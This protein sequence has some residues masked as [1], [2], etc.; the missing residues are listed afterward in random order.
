MI[1]PA[2]IPDADTRAILN[3]AEQEQAARFR[4]DKDARHWKACRTGLKAILAD[5]LGTGAGE[6]RLEFEEYGKPFLAAPHA[7][8][9][10]NL[11]HCHDLALVVLNLDGPVGIDIE[12]ADRGKSLI[13][14]EQA[15][16]HPDELASLPDEMKVRA[17]M[18]LDLWTCKEAL[19]KALGTGMSLAPETVSLIPPGEHGAGSHP[20]L[21]SFRLHRLDDPRLEKHVARVAV[22]LACREIV[23]AR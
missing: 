16:C 6:L 23:I 20:R 18:L 21:Q 15:F 13:G 4:F 14:C 10:F 1:D 7:E 9:H 11:S 22:P 3:A 19:L 12:P 8:L 5:A 2:A 17:A